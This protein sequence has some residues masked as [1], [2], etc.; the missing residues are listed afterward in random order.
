MGR[1]NIITIQ[2]DNYNPFCSKNPNYNKTLSSQCK[3][4]YIILNRIGKII[5]L[6]ILPYDYEIDLN[7]T[8]FKTLLIGIKRKKKINMRKVFS[9]FK[10]SG[11]KSSCCDLHVFRTTST[12]FHVKIAY[13]TYHNMPNKRSWL[14]GCIGV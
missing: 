5:H 12:S 8:V 13:H 9:L 10:N 2:V 14:V 3:R 1:E 4:K 11:R 7:K 6:Y